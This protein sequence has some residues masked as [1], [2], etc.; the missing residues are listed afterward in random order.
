MLGGE[1]LCPGLER[2]LGMGKELASVGLGGRGSAGREEVV[3][4]VWSS[5]TSACGGV[6]LL[7]RVEVVTK[8]IV[9]G[10]DGN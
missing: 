2:V 6:T 7:N 9:A 5:R 8:R 4:V 1:C 3:H 10:T